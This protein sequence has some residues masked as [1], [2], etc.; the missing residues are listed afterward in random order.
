M[1]GSVQPLNRNSWPLVLAIG[2]VT[3]APAA[4]SED[5]L[6]FYIGGAVGQSQLRATLPYPVAPATS[7][8]RNATGWKAMLGM[9][10]LSVLG[11]EI[12]YLDFGSISGTVNRAA[13]LN[14][15]GFSE[16]VSTRSR[17]AALFGVAYL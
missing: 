5:P 15:G 14:F 4:H 13:T 6:G 2:A 9:R 7:L 1:G 10:P 8:E 17:A 16:S 3:A 12:E 11:A